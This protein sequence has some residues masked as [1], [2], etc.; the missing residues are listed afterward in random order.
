MNINFV[1]CCR[2]NNNSRK[3]LPARLIDHSS[4]ICQHKIAAIKNCRTCELWDT[5]CRNS[6][7]FLKKKNQKYVAEF[8]LQFTELSLEGFV[9]FGKRLSG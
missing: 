4:A 1:A 5:V 7:E 9:Q 3:S 2:A 8:Q 6:L